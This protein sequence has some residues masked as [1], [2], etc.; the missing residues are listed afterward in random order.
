MVKEPTPNHTDNICWDGILTRGS[1]TPESALLILHHAVV[2][3]LL[4][5]ENVFQD[6]QEMPKTMDN[7]KPNIYCAFS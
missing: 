6:P 5:G 1:Q 2:P 3:L 7:T 4:Y